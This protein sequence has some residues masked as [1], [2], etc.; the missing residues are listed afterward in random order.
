MEPPHTI[1]TVDKFSRPVRRVSQLK[2][3]WRLP[4]STTTLG[5][6]LNRKMKRHRD[7]RCRTCTE[8]RETCHPKTTQQKTHS[9]QKERHTLNST[10][11]NRQE[12]PETRRPSRA[13]HSAQQDRD[14]S[15]SIHL[16]TSTLMTKPL[17]QSLGLQSQERTT[18]TAY[19]AT[20]IL[21]LFENDN[22]KIVRMVLLFSDFVIVSPGDANSVTCDQDKLPRQSAQLG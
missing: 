2:E 17:K 19:L 3:S 11:L 4:E 6:A 18:A 1:S 10:V 21:L 9:K 5:N 20:S 22:D 14:Q 12:L 13:S 7:C 15:K 16:G 8:P